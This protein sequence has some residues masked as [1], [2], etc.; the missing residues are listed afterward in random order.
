MTYEDR[1]RI[2]VLLLVAVFSVVP[3]LVFAGFVRLLAWACGLE[4]GPWWKFGTMAIA[5][6]IAARMFVGLTLFTSAELKKR[7][8]I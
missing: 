6:F 4:F 2:K 8:I 7:G 3:A 1:I 5:G